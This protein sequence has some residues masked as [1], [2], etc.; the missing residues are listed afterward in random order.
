VTAADRIEALR[1]EIRRHEELYYVHAQPE[2]SDAEFD[3]LMLKLRA[4][5]AEHPDLVTP[6]SPTQRVGGRP[7][8]GFVTVRHAVPMLSLD[9]AYD[10]ADLR[11][12]DERVRKGLGGVDSADYVCELKIDGLSI[13]LLY[14]HG[15]LLRGATRGDGV[16]GEDVTFNVRTIK[17]IPLR[18]EGA[19]RR[20]MEI[21]GEVYF[22]RKA[23]DRLNAEREQQGEPLFANPRNAAAGTMRTLDP[24]AVSRRGL[25][26]WLYQVVEVAVEVAGSGVERERAPVEER[27]VAGS[28]VERERAPGADPDAAT[29]TPANE[30]EF[31][32]HAAML[33]QLRAWGCPVEPHWRE[34]E[35]IDA[36]IAFCEEWRERR[37]QLPFETD[38]VVVK[39]ND[40]GL[41]ARLGTTSKFPRWATAFKYPAQQATT[42]LRKIEV[43]IGRTGAATPYAVLEP[44]LVAGSTIS[45]ATL[46]NP[47]DL[48]RKDIREGDTV[49]VEKAGDVIPR[50]VGPVLARRPAHSHPWT[51]PSKCP[52]CDSE[53]VKAEDEAVWRCENS[54]CP[55][56]LMRSLDHFVS[57]G[58]M[59][60]EGL[61][62]V[63]IRQ[64]VEKGLVHSAADIYRLTAETLEDLERMGK[65]SAAKLMGQIERSKANEI[66]R[67][68]NA[69]GIR[70]VGERGAQVL[71]DHFGSIEAIEAAPVEV[72][73]EVHEVGPVMAESV[74]S[75]FDEPR[76]RTLV[77]RLR[78]A[79]VRMVGERKTAPA[80]PRPLA[81]KTFVITGT[82]D[83]MSREDAQARIEALGGKVTGSVSKKTSYLV[84][85]AD[86]GS[87]L[88]KARALGVPELDEAAFLGLIMSES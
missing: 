28:G 73:Q 25:S 70:H 84:V 75:W 20:R 82:L 53:L 41:R 86:A 29:G 13:S 34:V 24:T 40:L 39:L 50:V 6:D 88:D 87:K 61:G 58:A 60:I 78:E 77:S 81:G 56:R 55:A 47:D 27:E 23:F 71:A 38:G 3:A 37:H 69:L 10:E 51:M 80:G 79:G 76:N 4:L 46:H 8:E 12:F 44:V 26:A 22:P 67:L 65:K 62:E 31:A 72:L 2:I 21:R 59:N 48:A 5:E 7:A 63:L 68:L 33:K 42:L 11:A 9:N 66:W 36:V 16:Q 52:V 85:G 30:A 43:N 32:T 45:L 1:R 17:A 49:I 57:R 18:L 74:R 15:R 64:L 14:E 35:G 54:S 19:P 83:A